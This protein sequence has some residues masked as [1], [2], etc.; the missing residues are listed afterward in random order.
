MFGVSQQ[1]GL[2]VN[3]PVIHSIVRAG[4]TQMGQPASIFHTTQQQSRVIGQQ[5]GSGIEYAVDRIGPVVCGQDG[6][7]LMP[8]KEFVVVMAHGERGST[9]SR[10]FSARRS[11]SR[12]W[13][14]A[15]VDSAP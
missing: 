11:S 12:A 13:R 9:D 10:A 1:R 3:L 2:R 14:K 6:I 7:E 4:H 8:A 15:S 5:C